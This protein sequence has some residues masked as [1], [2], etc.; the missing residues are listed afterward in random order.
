MS[1]PSLKTLSVREQLFVNEYLQRVGT[2]G[3]GSE[4]AIAAG[5]SP[6]SARQQASRLLTKANIQ[7]AIQERLAALEMD[8]DEVLRK[9]VEQARGTMGDFI[10]LNEDGLPLLDFRQA[11]TLG[12]LQTLKRF[13]HTREVKKFGDDE[14][15]KDTYEVELYDAQAA[16]HLLGKH[17]KL[18]D[19]A[20]EGD[21]QREMEAAG[22]NPSDEFE[23]LVQQ[24][25]TRLAAGDPGDAGGSVGGGESPD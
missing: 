15:T 18:F 21:W 3:N 19:R 14:I 20:L 7:R 6:K 16:L 5:Y 13:K 17:H 8:A 10:T 22:L 2:R 1:D 23:K 24:Y 25:Q 4:A 12:K 9:L 11:Q